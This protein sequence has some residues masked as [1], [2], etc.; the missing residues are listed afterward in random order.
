MAKKK[1]ILNVS[2]HSKNFKNIAG[3]RFGILT[4]IEPCGYDTDN[5]LLWLCRCDC[6]NYTKVSGKHLRN[7]NTKSCGCL[8]STTMAKYNYRHGGSVRGHRDR[9]YGIYHDMLR[10]CYDPRRSSYHRYGGRGIYVCD[11]WRD[12]ET[13]YQKFKSWAYDNGF[14]DQPKDTPIKELISIDRIDNDGPYAPWNCRWT[15][16]TV[17]SNNRGVFNQQIQDSDGSVMNFAE[18]QAK[19]GL[20]RAAIRNRL[21]HGWTFSQIVYAAHNPELNM[22]YETNKNHVFTDSDGFIH[23]IPKIDQSKARNHYGD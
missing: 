22:G 21:V 23:L 15:D 10:R 14:Y 2:R 16:M 4:A 5:R 1:P 11:E 7:G 3:E 17:Q 12:K 6:G 8:K 19:Y 18:F 20:K 9:L 13:G